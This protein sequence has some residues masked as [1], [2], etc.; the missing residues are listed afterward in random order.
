[1]QS[2][3]N[4]VYSVTAEITVYEALKVMEDKN[5]GALVVMDGDSLKGIIS[6][7]DYARKV[8]LKGLSSHETAVSEIMTEKVI[9]VLPEDDIDK[10]MGLMSGRKI[11]HLPVLKDEN[12]LGIISITDVVTAIIESQKNTIAQLESYISQ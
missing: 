1:M 11:R 10:C 4:N 6:E 5:V 8:I 12:L 3:G 2:K 9:T 7:R